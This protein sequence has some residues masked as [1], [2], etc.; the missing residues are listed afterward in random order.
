[1]PSKT[2]TPEIHVD[3]IKE[4]TTTSRSKNAPAKKKEAGEIVKVEKDKM[5]KKFSNNTI[6]LFLNNFVKNSDLRNVSVNFSIWDES[7]KKNPDIDISSS[8]EI[9]TMTKAMTNVEKKDDFKSLHQD[10]FTPYLHTAL[11]YVQSIPTHNTGIERLF[12]EFGFVYN[13]E[14]NCNM[15]NDYVD[16]WINDKRRTYCKIFNY[17]F[18]PVLKEKYPNKQDVYKCYL[19]Y[20]PTCINE[21]LKIKFDNF[22]KPL[23]EVLLQVFPKSDITTVR[24]KQIIKNVIE[25]VENKNKDIDSI[26]KELMNLINIIE[27][28]INVIG[29]SKFKEL[30]NY[31]NECCDE[32]LKF[33][34]DMR[35][36]YEKYKS[37]PNHTFETF[38]YMTIMY[39]KFFNKFN[40]KNGY[41]TDV[42]VALRK[43]NININF[44]NKKFRNT[45]NELVENDIDENKVHEFC[46]EYQNVVGVCMFE[47]SLF[48]PMDEKIYDKIGFYYYKSNDVPNEC[49]QIPKKIRIA[50]GFAIFARIFIYTRAKVLSNTKA[51]NF[52]I[53]IKF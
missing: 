46:Q 45:L 48:N 8:P 20:A 32:Y 43:F 30:Y 2:K 35:E 5:S 18:G 50:L 4:T 22:T 12:N 49:L 40:D 21:L 26:V 41:N 13:I 3:L 10:I 44:K 15:V 38:V 11:S 34:T 9:I 17:V 1:M 39:S 23:N 27:T 29:E 53:C 42:I 47:D 52:K 7:S 25:K 6:K 37:V 28:K 36:Y 19:Q 33:A 51:K 16:T 31:Y 24:R 14:S